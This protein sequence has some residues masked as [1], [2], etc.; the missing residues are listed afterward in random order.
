MHAPPTLASLGWINHH[1]GMYAKKVAIASLLYSIVCGTKYAAKGGFDPEQ[2]VLHGET[3]LLI[4][5]EIYNID[6]EL[7]ELLD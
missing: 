5:W 2:L 4:A 6:W 7:L 3:F 1:D